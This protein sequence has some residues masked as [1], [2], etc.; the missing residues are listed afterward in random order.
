MRGVVEA[1]GVDRFDGL[2]FPG[3][4]V[5]VGEARPDVMRRGKHAVWVAY[6]ESHFPVATFRRLDD[7][8]AF[9]SEL[10]ALL[11]L[12]VPAPAVPSPAPGSRAAR[13][14]AR[15]LRREIER[16]ET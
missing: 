5:R 13:R 8:E 9:A 6:G 11:G 12:S 4:T 1:R 14:A 15:E 7:A 2:P 3:V 10:R 16:G